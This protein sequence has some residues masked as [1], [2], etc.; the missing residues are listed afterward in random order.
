MLFPYAVPFSFAYTRLPTATGALIL[1]GCVQLTMMSAARLNARCTHRL[2]PPG[3]GDVRRGLES[4]RSG[5][6]EAGYDP[7]AFA[8]LVTGHGHHCETDADA[9]PCLQLATGNQTVFADR[10]SFGR[11]RKHQ[12]HRPAAPEAPSAP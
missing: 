12:E 4:R 11:S 5:F 1:F 9:D 3:N 8:A 6:G 7:A 10:S 2:R